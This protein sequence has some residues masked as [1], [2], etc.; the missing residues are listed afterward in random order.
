MRSNKLIT[1]KEKGLLIRRELDLAQKASIVP[2]KLD[3]EKAKL[4]K[5]I[6]ENGYEVIRQWLVNQPES[7]ID[8]SWF[9]MPGLVLPGIDLSGAILNALSF[10]GGV[11]SGAN[12]TAAS[13][14][15]AIGTK[16]NL[17]GAILSGANLSAAILR[18]A[19]L[20]GAKL[21]GAE[22]FAPE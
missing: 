9:A 12:L 8:L 10:S 13:M 1:R 19:D 4:L 2:K 15:G 11:L 7:A 17:R 16:A 18:G 6:H 22:R 20:S 5:L 14:Y 3:R 21:V